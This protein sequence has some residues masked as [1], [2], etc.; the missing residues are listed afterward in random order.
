[1]GDIEC[2][3]NTKGEIVVSPCYPSTELPKKETSDSDSDS[4]SDN[5]NTDD[6]EEE[7]IEVVFKPS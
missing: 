5:D 6:D 3:I 1:M 2:E 4:D 7:D